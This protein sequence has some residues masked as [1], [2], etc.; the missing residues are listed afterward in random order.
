M[1]VTVGL[2][3]WAFKLSRTSAVGRGPI[4]GR[5]RRKEEEEDVPDL[6]SIDLEP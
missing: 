6:N 1:I 5:H 3:A 4:V 2:S